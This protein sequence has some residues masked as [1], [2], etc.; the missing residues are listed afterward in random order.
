VRVVR[1]RIVSNETI[2]NLIVRN[3]VLK[4]DAY[5]ALPQQNLEG[6]NVHSS[7]LF[8]AWAL[9]RPGGTGC[10]RSGSELPAR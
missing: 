1:K 10:F 3:R 9:S 2:D 7:S 5:R 8:P 6:L 4:K